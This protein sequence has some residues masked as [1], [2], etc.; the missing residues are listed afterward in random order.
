MHS[1]IGGSSQVLFVYPHRCSLQA[2]Y[3]IVPVAAMSNALQRYLGYMFTSKFKGSYMCFPLLLVRRQWQKD[4]KPSRNSSGKPKAKS[5]PKGSKKKKDQ[6]DPKSSKSKKVSK[7]K[8]APT[9][10]AE[11][12]DAG[13]ESKPSKKKKRA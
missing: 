10:P 4:N 2:W 1:L 12:P 13:S 5:Q 3:Y 7:K 9:E 11:A 6:N 8:K